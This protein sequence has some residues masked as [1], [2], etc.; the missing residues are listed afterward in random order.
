MMNEKEQEENNFFV[1]L[2]DEAWLKTQYQM[3]CATQLGEYCLV[4]FKIKRLRIYNRL[5]G[6][7]AGDELIK[8]VYHH[9][10]AFIEEDEKVAHIHAGEFQLLMKFSTDYDEV[11]QKII[12]FNNHFI[13][14]PD[15][16][17][18]G[19]VYMG[20]GI[21]RINEPVDFAIAQYNAE[22]CRTESKEALFRN[23]HFEIYGEKYHDQNLVNFRAEHQFKQAL[24][25]GHICFYLQP[26]ID[27]KTG[28]LYGAEAL[29]RWIDPVRGVIPLNEFLPALEQNGLIEDLDLYIFEKVCELILYFIHTYGKKLRISVNLSH[30]LFNY[31]YFF[32][33]YKEIHAKYPCPKEC[34]EIE[35]LESIVLNQVDM[36][37]GVVQQIHDYGFTCALDDFGSGY[38]SFSVLTSS[39]ID[40]LKIDQSLFRDGM[41]ERECI[42]VNHIIET[43][44]ELHMNAI[45]EG[46]E[47]LDTMKY[48]IAL[49]CDA[50]Q[51]YIFYKAMPV[52]EFEERFMKGNEKVDFSNFG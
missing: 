13:D 4:S 44:K 25:N 26:K 6:H 42:I 45:A 12:R 5:F 30:C 52:T 35:L 32:N 22:I 49:G 47:T 41:N 17:D 1:D 7:H 28:E 36:V 33:L 11:Y 15:P 46:V 14:M 27:L 18:A 21:Y 48:L 3:I 23:T 10:Q 19:R 29:A 43:A 50:I 39:D 34:I 24:D 37:K 31:R 9:I 51:G 40:C 20:L 2:H 38:S 16:Y 8:R